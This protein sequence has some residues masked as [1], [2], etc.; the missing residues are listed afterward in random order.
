MLE[1][2]EGLA[3]LVEVAREHPDPVMRR[4]AVE[5]LRRNHGL[6]EAEIAARGIAPEET[7]KLDA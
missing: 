5:A 6:S 4:H 7:K 3:F 1:L 2:P